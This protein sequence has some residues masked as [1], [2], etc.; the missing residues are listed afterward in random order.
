MAH[1]RVPFSLSILTLAALS[2]CAS[3]GSGSTNPPPMALTITTASLLGGT[4]S[5]SYGPATLNATGGS[6]P[7]MWSW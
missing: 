5:V 1:V 4:T 2:A 7:Y 6:A 3:C